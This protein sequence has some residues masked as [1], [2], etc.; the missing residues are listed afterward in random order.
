MHNDKFLPRFALSLAAVM[1]VTV[2]VTGVSIA[3]ELP[4]AAATPAAGGDYA[5]SDTCVACH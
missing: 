1:L 5:G 4:K 3:G 2:L